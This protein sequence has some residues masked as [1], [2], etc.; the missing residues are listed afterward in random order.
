MEWTKINIHSQDLILQSTFI[1]PHIWSSLRS[2]D[3][4][5]EVPQTINSPNIYRRDDLKFSTFYDRITEILNR[6]FDCHRNEVD[7][8]LCMVCFY[9]L[10]YGTPFN[11]VKLLDTSEGGNCTHSDHDTMR[12]WFLNTILNHSQSDKFPLFAEKIFRK[13]MLAFLRE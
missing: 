2:A 7:H 1:P 6:H 10:L 4:F 8:I 3:D 5:R 9:A 13:L 12:K 11:P